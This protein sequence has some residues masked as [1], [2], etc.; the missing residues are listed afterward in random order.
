MERDQSRSYMTSGGG[1]GGGAKAR[2]GRTRSSTSL[3][4]IDRMG[5]GAGT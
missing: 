5:T 2:S 4:Q 3:S 1:A